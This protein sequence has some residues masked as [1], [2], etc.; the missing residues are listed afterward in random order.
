[1]D[2]FVSYTAAD[3]AWA[4][5]IGTQLEAAGQRV[6]VLAAAQEHRGWAEGPAELAH[7]RGELDAV[8]AVG[9]I[10]GD[11]AGLVAGGLGGLAVVRGGLLAGGV[12]G[13]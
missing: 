7:D 3:E 4:T 12:A 2:F 10:G 6:R 8:G 9:V 11:A 5:W 13:F 1:M